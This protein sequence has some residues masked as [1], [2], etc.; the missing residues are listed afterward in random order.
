MSNQIFKTPVPNELLFELLE[1]IAFK[2]NKYYL[3]NNDSYKKGM[4]NETIPNFIKLCVQYYHS[5]KLKYVE[6]P[7]TYTSFITIIRQ[8][9]RFN[10]IKY[11]SKIKYT[12]ST[13]D[14]VYFVYFA[15]T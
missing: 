6:K 11:N 4:F 9:C 3:L 5:S 13:Y 7:L 12:K 14:I 10:N 1:N 15:P 2:T 8:I